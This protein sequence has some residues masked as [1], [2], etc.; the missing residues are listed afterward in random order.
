MITGEQI[1][2]ARELIGKIIKLPWCG[3]RYDG[4]VKYSIRGNANSEVVLRIDCNNEE[5][6]IAGDNEELYIFE[7]C[8][9]YPAAL[10]EI[11]KLMLENRMWT[12]FM[13]IKELNA[14]C[15]IC[16]DCAVCMTHRPKECRK[17]IFDYYTANPSEL[18]EVSK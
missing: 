7:A 18:S 13:N 9:N 5:Y 10:D 2:S 15:P 3:D 11:E 14:G 16:G 1:K 4:T 17:M 12:Q 8:N 6:G